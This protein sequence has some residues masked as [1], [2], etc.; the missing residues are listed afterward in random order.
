MATTA[1][2]TA[3]VVARAR[4]VRIC[5]TTSMLAPWAP[6]EDVG[7]PEAP[8]VPNGVPSVRAV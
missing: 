3:N 1:M 5:G 6:T 7:Y 4:L 2:L 8:L